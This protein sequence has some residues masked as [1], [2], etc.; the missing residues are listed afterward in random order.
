VKLSGR[1]S[2]RFCERPDQGLVGALLFGPDASVVAAGRRG[3]VS[4]IAEDDD[5]RITRLEGSALRRD[6]A[7][8]D[9]ALRAR[10]FF[11]GRRV[12]L[13][14]GAR[15]ELTQIVKPLLE[16]LS[17]EDAFL[18][19][20][21]GALAGKSTL[22][23]L[24]EGAR[25]VAACGLYPD[26]VDAADALRRLKEA[27]MTAGLAPEAEAALH[28]L[29]PDLD[30]AQATQFIEKIA[31]FGLDRE[32]PVSADDVIALAPAAADAEID[33]LVEVVASGRA[34]EVA[35]LLSR[36]AGGG[37]SPV[38]AI[39]AMGRHFRQLLALASAPDGPEAAINR[40]RPPAFGP[41][42]QALMR[43]ARIWTRP[44]AE[45]AVRLLQE[46]DRTLRSPGT[47][48][49]RTLVERCFIRLAMMGAR[50]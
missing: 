7:A 15:D 28:G 32:A 31:L 9:E 2:A 47:R 40:L 46:T 20:E 29:L 18:V 44:R 24:F 23:K 10:G 6:P 19:M 27:G 45:A 14:E 8:L 1:D 35:P 25:S 42:R 49:D 12:V 5:L 13:V 39:I 22:R 4:C 34:E 50:G 38:Q 3:L 48:P 43:Q 26:P 36:I 41:R 21:A 11:P 17:P 16:T 33:R 30:R 37:A